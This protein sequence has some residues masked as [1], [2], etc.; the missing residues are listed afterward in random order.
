V[1][2]VVGGAVVARAD[3]A[4]AATGSAT[5]STD[6][7][8]GPGAW[9]GPRPRPQ[10]LLLSFLGALVLDGRDE[11]LPTLVF[12]HVLREL[13]IADAAG[14]ATLTRLAR[15]GLLEREQRGRV[16]TFALT[17]SSR[18][19]LRQGRERIL[20]LE[21]FERD[22]TAWT[23]L[24][25]SLP[26]AHRDLR[27]QLRSRLSWAGF[28][29]LRDGLW[30]APG[31]VDLGRVLGD[32]ADIPGLVADG[33]LAQPVAGA[34]VSQFV[35]RAWDLPA[36][37]AEHDRFLHEWGNP[38]A[39]DGDPIARL[40]LLN[41]H[42]VHLLRVDPGLPLQHLPPG[43]PAGASA[44]AYRRATAVLDPWA[45]EAFEELVAAAWRRR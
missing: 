38:P 30:I 2:A 11:P 40:T 43:W 42:W 36:L 5:G 22:A 27:H 21:P 39:A 18:S 4:R 7:G 31:A 41:A 23:L 35:E 15:R 16:A 8:R 37:Q 20:A 12:L 6:D 45:R 3:L 32:T 17:A 34:Q 26:E 1:E 10:Q 33:F 29:C 14:R 19:L 44:E 13:G 25:F 28:G 9:P 24:S